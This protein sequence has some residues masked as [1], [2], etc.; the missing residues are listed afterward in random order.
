[1]KAEETA[2]MQR[3]VA[4]CNGKLRPNAVACTPDRKDLT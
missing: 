4:H 3:L 2:C 1:M